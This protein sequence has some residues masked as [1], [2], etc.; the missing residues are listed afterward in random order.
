[1]ARENLKITD[2][3]VTIMS[4]ELKDKEWVIGNVVIWKTDAV[5]VEIFTDKGIV[6]IGESSP[7]GEPENM[8]K[9][10]EESIKPALLGKNPFDV[11][12]L[13]RP[14]ALYAARPRPG[15]AWT[16]PC[17]DIIGKAGEHAGVQAAGHRCPPHDRTSGC[18][19]PAASS[20]PGTSGP[21]T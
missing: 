12:H 3:K 14:G 20:T 8:K 15:R 1:M 13:A 10:I 4:Y 18:T 7:Y 9:T 6:G 19:P 2:I 21:K 16:R 11:E 5:L 17:W